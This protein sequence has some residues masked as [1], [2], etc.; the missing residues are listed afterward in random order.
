M[1]Q[2]MGVEAEVK[3]ETG[4]WAEEAHSACLN[5]SH[6]ITES[7]EDVQCQVELLFY[8]SEFPMEQEI[9]LRVRI[10]RSKIS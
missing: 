10:S 8:W 7:F 3:S 4:R 2:G 5:R 1:I 6:H 9:R